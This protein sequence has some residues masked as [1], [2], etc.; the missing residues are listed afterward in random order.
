MSI[1]DFTV[2]EIK[3]A[4]NF[5]QLKFKDYNKNLGTFILTPDHISKTFNC[6][7]FNV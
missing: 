1:T 7:Y 2:V 4:V 6:S 3:G 5:L